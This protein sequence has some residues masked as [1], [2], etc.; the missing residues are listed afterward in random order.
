MV[1]EPCL[2]TIFGF[3]K[4][5]GVPARTLLTLEEENAH[6]QERK[7]LN[8]LLDL[9]TDEQLRLAVQISRLIYNYKSGGETTQSGSLPL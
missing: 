8:T 2:N 5:L 4:G 3:A 6:D 9:F 1:Q 7:E